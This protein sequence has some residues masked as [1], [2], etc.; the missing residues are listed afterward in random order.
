LVQAL[1]TVVSRRIG[2]LQPAVVSV[3]AIHGGEAWNIIPEK[4][5]LRGTARSLENT[6]ARRIRREMHRIVRGT[7]SASGAKCELEYLWGYPPLVN[8]QAMCDRVAAAVKDL[9]GTGALRRIEEP[10]MG[11][12]DFTYFLKRVPGAMIHLGVKPGKYY[13]LHNA[14][15]NLDEN[16]LPVG[17]AVMVKTVVDYL[18]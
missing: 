9:F 17:V 2:P 8:N 1:Q 16:V 7:A 3:C 15:F 6:V 13:P 10:S 5:V 12:E 4:V 14:R 18:T 11:G